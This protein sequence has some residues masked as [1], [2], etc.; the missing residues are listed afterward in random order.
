VLSLFAGRLVQLQGMESGNYRKLASQE[1]DRTIVLPALR[2]GITG[3]NGQV[4]A[5]TVAQY[6]VTA[7]PPQ[8]PLAK[9]Q[10]VADA[11]AGPLGMTS[12]AI[13]DK[14]QHPTS[15]QYVVLAKGVPAQASGQITALHL[16]GIYQT[17]SYARS[18]P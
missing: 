12:A 4:L 5:M 1:R 3:A 10:Q 8:I 18:Y 7:D 11:L 13:L 9:R 2:G 15:P 14:I 17:A 16:S 6:Q